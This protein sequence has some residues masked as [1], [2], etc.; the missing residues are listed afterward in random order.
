MDPWWA[1][2]AQAV[3][4]AVV[5]EY[6]ARSC[7]ETTRVAV[8]VAAYFGV[9]L[10]PHAVAVSVHTPDNWA[11]LD[12]SGTM[13]DVGWSVGTHGD[14]TIDGLL[15]HGHLIALAEQ[16]RILLDISADQF[17]R[18]AKGLLVPGPVT[19]PLGP[20]DDLGAGIA[21]HANDGGFVYYVQSS[22]NEAWRN[23][24]AWQARKDRARR[25]AGT[26][27]RELRDTRA[28]AGA[29]R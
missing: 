20:D 28:P 10:E 11:A 17:S 9:T 26:V 22:G 8:Y 7:V 24:P 2:F 15:W 6:G 23:F 5:P 1:Q 21:A 18:P 19:M 29:A 27:I 3:R 12:G 16:R 25:V 14:G 13:P 4:T